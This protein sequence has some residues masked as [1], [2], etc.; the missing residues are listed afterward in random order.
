MYKLLPTLLG[1]MGRA[2]P[3]LLRAD[4]LISETLKLEESKFRTTLA[5]GLS[6]L[7]DATETLDKGDSLM[8]KRRS[9]F[10]TPMVFR[11]I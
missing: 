10:T 9:N 3:E 2:Y 8:A 7:S 4:S 6:L 11:L 1:E 5:R